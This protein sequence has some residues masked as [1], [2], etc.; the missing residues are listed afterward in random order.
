MKR[1]GITGKQWALVLLCII[2]AASAAYVCGRK[3][4]KISSLSAASVNGEVIP[5]E[6]VYFYARYYQSELYRTMKDSFHEDF[7]NQEVSDGKN[8]GE[9]I[10]DSAIKDLEELVLI[11]QHAKDYEV[12]MTR[13][14]EALTARLAREFLERNSREDLEA[15]FADYDT[16][17]EFLELILL[18]SKIYNRV[19]DQLNIQVT[20]EQARQKKFSYV[21]FQSHQ[22][23]RGEAPAEGE[24][25]TEEDREKVRER[26]G[27]L[28]EEIQNPAE[29]E[30]TAREKGYTVDSQ[31]FGDETAIHEPL[32]EALNHME[33]GQMGPVVDT[34]VG[35]YVIRLDSKD[36][37]ADTERKRRELLEKK[38]SRSFEAVQQIWM[39]ESSIWENPD[40]WKDFPMEFPQ[41]IQM[42]ELPYSQ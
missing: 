15:S 26:A 9:D 13:E 36:V 38:R 8:Y 18:E 6:L 7:W 16:V 42:V 39:E 27:A 35:F 41:G 19:L 40:L 21:F 23:L 10:K 37:K 33:E 25:E 17:K 3:A 24:G 5:K 12:E 34:L 32:K 28:L 2:L 20:S 1:I 29:F 4:V 30:E 14:D 11:R 31:I 22:L